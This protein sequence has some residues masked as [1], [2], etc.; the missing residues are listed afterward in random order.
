RLLNNDRLEQKVFHAPLPDVKKLRS[1]YE[2]YNSE[3][4]AH[5][6]IYVEASRGCP[7]K[8]EFCLSSLDIPVRPFDTSKFMNDMED[9]MK[10]GVTRFKF[11]DRTFNLSTQTGLKLLTFFLERYR[12]GMFL[13]FEM[14][15]DRLPVELREQISQFPKGALQFEIGIQTFNPEV[16]TRI[17]RRQNYSQIDGNLLYLKKQTGVYLH[18]DLIVGLPGEDLESFGS[19][20]DHLVSL[21]PHEIQVGILKRLKG[22]PI[23]RHDEPWGMC[24]NDQPPFDLLFNHSLNFQTMQRLKRFA[25]YWDLTANSGRFGQSVTLIWEN[26]ESPFREFMKWSDWLYS[27]IGRSHSIGLTSLMKFLLEYLVSDK[28]I[29]DQQVAESILD[30]YRNTGHLDTPRFLAKHLPKEI[31]SGRYQKL[32]ISPFTK[33]QH[34]HIR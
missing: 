34:R 24:Y 22:T 16:A 12:E 2:Y 33:R 27:K 15:P 19:G 1:P 13:H 5:R 32:K 4:L 6:V 29:P 31:N 7:F 18:V 20:F 28:D 14:I 25:R 26:S 3:D 21:R 8:C 10:R 11:V 23:G 30:D 9:L 17:H